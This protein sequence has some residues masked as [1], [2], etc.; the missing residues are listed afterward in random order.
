MHRLTIV[1]LFCFLTA[2]WLL[3]G[4]APA[5]V[6]KSPSVLYL[7]WIH[8]PCTTM[9]VQWH[10]SSDETMSQVEYRKTGESEWQT[11]DGIYAPLPN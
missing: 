5:S 10:T 9:T 6:A 2:G 3:F 7:T 11:Q 4:A 1:R 8:D